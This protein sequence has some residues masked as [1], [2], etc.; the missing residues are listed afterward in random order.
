MAGSPIGGWEGRVQIGSLFLN[1]E[2][3]EV[4]PEADDLPTQNFESL[5]TDGL[6]YKEGIYGFIGAKVTFKGF[7]DAGLDP[8][9]TTGPNLRAG[10]I[11]ATAVLL[12]VRKTGARCFT[13]PNFRITST[14]VVVQAG[15]KVMLSVSGQ[16]QGQFTY[17]S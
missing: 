10:V 11:L 13:F 8:H 6:P 5:G 1:L 17:P 3:W 12:Y 14:P 9:V 7:W 2:E 4:T 15:G 16:N